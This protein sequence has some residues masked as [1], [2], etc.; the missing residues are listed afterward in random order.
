M[1]ISSILSGGDTVSELLT[2]IYGDL[3]KTPFQVLL[4]LDR[5]TVKEMDVSKLNIGDVVVA[6]YDESIPEYPQKDFGRVIEIDDK[7]VTFIGEVSNQ[8]LTVP[9]RH[10]TIPLDYKWSDSVDRYVLGAMSIEETYQH[11]DIDVFKKRL[12]DSLYQE[13]IVPG[14]RV[15]ASMGILEKYNKQYDLTAYNCYVLPNPKDSRK[16]IINGSLSEMTEIMSRGGGVGIAL[17]TL[18]PR[19][20]RV[21]GVNGI[22][23]GSVSWGGLLSYATGL[24]EQGGSRKGALMLQLHISHPDIFDFITVKRESGKITNANLS[25]QITKEFMEAVENDADWHLIFP[26]TRHE[27]YD[28]DW[29]EKYQDIH[30]WLESGLPVEVYQTIK[31]RELYDLIIESAHASAE[32]GV[33]VYDHMNDGYMTSTQQL[34]PVEGTKL[35]KLDPASLT[36]KHEATPWN[37][38]FYYQK[39]VSSNPCG[40]QPLC[41]NGICNLIHINLAEFYDEKTRDVDWQDLKQAVADAIRYADDV[42]DYTVYFRE[43]NKK[44]QK[45]QRRIGMGT[46]GLHDLLIDLQLRYGSDESIVFIDKLY[47]FIKNSAYE[48]SAKLAEIRGRFPKFD[49]R[50]LDARIPKSLDKDVRALIKKHGLRNS[51]LLTQAPT[52]T[53]GTKTGSQGYSRSTG[54][55]P[56]FSIKWERESRLGKTIDYLGKAK[57]YLERTGEKT[58]PDYFVSAM[59]V[60]QDGTPKITPK[61]HVDVQATIQKH[62]DSAISKTS[63]VPNH[64]TVEQTKELYSYGIEKGVVGLTIY[65]DGSR[66]TQVLRSVS[67]EEETEK[68][69]EVTPQPITFEDDDREFASTAKFYKRPTRLVGETIKSATPFGKMYVTVNRHPQTDLIEEVFLNLGKTGADIS[70]IA[71]GLAI[72]LTGL[73]SPRI[74]NLT[75]QEKVNWIIKKFTGIK[76]QSAVG[77]GK[78]QIESLPDALA[79][80]LMQLGE[81]NEAAL[82]TSETMNKFS[83]GSVDI[84]PSCGQSTFVKQDGCTTCLT[85]LGGCG[86]SKC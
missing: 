69:E 13:K 14:G 26:D 75:Q 29:A 82:V 64:F 15:Q 34:I 67:D 58:L 44:I 52:G 65:R 72:A 18:R 76:G 61:N 49:D 33:M 46:L 12:Y 17:S 5:Y 59:C 42:I 71:D 56:F 70:T 53:T 68:V 43:E 55:E 23:S 63:N 38:T 47:G 57:D 73:L 9:S 62:N 81:D 74:A 51:H 80:V 11:K 1:S 32:P 83:N 28:K 16:G 54:V 10:V 7:T 84:C 31:A 48:A 27:A 77:F 4:Q 3:K 60:E 78:N 40:E 20:A 24:I 6:I 66:D 2:E 86:Y 35:F 25:V 41:G 21:Y 8:T 22:S 37:N 36:K 79:K 30:D 85:D 19:N 39:N 45:E 50:I